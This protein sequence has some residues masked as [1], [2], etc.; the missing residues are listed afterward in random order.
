MIWGRKHIGTLG[1]NQFRMTNGILIQIEQNGGIVQSAATGSVA[2]DLSFGDFAEFMRRVFATNVKGQPNERMAIGGD[3]VLSRLNRMA[4]LDGAYQLNQTDTKFGIAITT[5]VTPFG[6][7]KLMTHPLMNENPVWQTEMY[8]VHP[9]GITRRMLRET[10]NEDYDKNGNRI[11][12]VDADQGVMTT[13][14]GVEV[15]A[16][17][18]MGIL[19][20][21]QKADKTA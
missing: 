13:E 11:S 21:V 8:V 6:S 7:L 3:L 14:M 9:G 20:N 5:F 10:F 17:S 18:T 2:G 4:Q 12:G 1:G 15:G 16:A 19:R